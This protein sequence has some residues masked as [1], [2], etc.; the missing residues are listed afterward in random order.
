MTPSLSSIL[1]ERY[2]VT[3]LTS[4]AVAI[5]WAAD[6]LAET[7]GLEAAQVAL[8]AA[9]RERE[10]AGVIPAY[11][12]Y[13]TPLFHSVAA[14]RTAKRAASARKGAKTRAR[15]APWMPRPV[16]AA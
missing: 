12:E 14:A 2:R 3:V 6:R 15:L 4:P 11:P 9:N 7:A 13:G 8:S 10:R 5:L 16:E 1:S